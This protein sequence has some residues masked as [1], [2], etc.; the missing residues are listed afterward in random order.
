MNNASSSNYIISSD[1]TDNI[2][3]TVTEEILDE[4]GRGDI[5][6]VDHKVKG[7]LKEFVVEELK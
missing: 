3:E 6:F 2:A 1:R 4:F 7:L 5:K